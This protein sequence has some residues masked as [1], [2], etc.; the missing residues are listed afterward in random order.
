MLKQVSKILLQVGDKYVFSKKREPWSSSKDHKLELI[1]GAIEYNETPFSGLIRE[2]KEEE[3]SGILSE[4]A[5]RL[6]PIP[7]KLYVGNEPHFIYKITI[8]NDEYNKMLHNV[9][10]SYGFDLIQKKVIEDKPTLKKNISFF[11]PKTIRIFHALN[12]L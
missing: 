4:K 3:V 6:N 5:K 2:L 9:S 8:S 7:I 11:T 10:E 12:F 1:G